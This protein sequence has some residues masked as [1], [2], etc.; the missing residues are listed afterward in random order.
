M[1]KKKDQTLK[2][3]KLEAFELL[4]AQRQKEEKIDKDEKKDDGFISKLTE[5]VVNNLQ[6]II[7]SVHFRYED[8]SDIKNPIAC[9]ITLENLTI[10]SCTKEW[11]K[12]FI[13]EIG[14]EIFK[15]L[16]LNKLSIYLNNYEK[17]LISTRKNIEFKEFINEMEELI[18]DKKETTF[19]STN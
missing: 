19:I 3:Q 11:K 13:N 5:T 1:R 18:L 12:T 16:E 15:I 8:N 17:S 4:K 2:Q 6:V 7:K 10:G 9:G 14:S